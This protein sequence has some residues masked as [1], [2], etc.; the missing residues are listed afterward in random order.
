M[1][2]AILVCALLAAALGCGRAARVHR[3]GEEWL[4]EIRLVGNTALATDDLVPGLALHR[5]L[6]AERALDPYQLAVDTDRLRAA[7]VKAGFFQVTVTPGVKVIGAEQ[8]VTF[9]IVEGPRSR[10]EVVIVGL[11]PEVPFEA[12]RALVAAKD[13]TPFDYDA[14][15][16]AKQPMVTLVENAGYPQVGVDAAVLADKARGVVVARFAIEPGPRARFGPVTIEGTDGD[17]AGAI[18]GRLAFQTGEVYSA[19]ALAESQRAIYALDRFS[20]VRVEPDRSAGA[21]VPVRI[22]VSLSNR[23]ELQL[24]FGAGYDPLNVEV[25]GRIGGSYVNA[26]HPLWTFAADFRPAYAAVHHFDALDDGL[27]KL[28]TLVSATRME[29]F[30]PHVRGELELSADYLT[31]EAYTSKGPRFRAG[32]SA[33]LGLASLQIR[34]GWLIEALKF[35][36]IQVLEPTRSALRL[37][38]IQRRGAYELSLVGDWRD[39]AIEPHRGVFAQLRATLG[40]R[41]AGGDIEYRQLTPEVRLYLPLPR[42][43]V[44]AGRARVGVIFGSVPVTERYFAGGANSQRGFAERR[45]SPVAATKDGAVVIGGAGLVETGLELRVPIGKL[46]KLGLG[47]QLFL[48]GGDVTEDPSD[49]DPGHLHWATGL[50][51]YAGFQGFKVRLDFGYRLNRRGAGEPQPGENFAFHL[52]VGDTF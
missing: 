18:I 50:G 38:E 44:L 36:N 27:L 39:N 43:S 22:T 12:A 37:D 13:G 40:T 49:L 2:A 41:F 6:E 51:L 14:Y 42:G 7:Y 30:R 46:G 26:A 25:R 21:V 19:A 24:G 23:H 4:A 16:A 8:H 28:R 20:A 48:D 3:P 1:R 47:T 15:D 31:V 45:L 33:P 32:A 9:T 52:G 29:L 11:P 17:L 5:N 10:L 35:T 34:A